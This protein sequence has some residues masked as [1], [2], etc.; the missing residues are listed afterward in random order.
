MAP[1]MKR[2]PTR[3]IIVHGLGRDH[4]G[5]KL[6][7]GIT[8]YAHEFGPWF[9]WISPDRSTFLSALRTWKADGVFYRGTPDDGD[10]RRLRAAR[11]AAIQI[12]WP[13]PGQ[14]LD[15]WIS[16][17]L[18]SAGELAARHLLE[19]G[20][21]R[22]GYY[23]PSSPYCLARG[24]GFA[25]A[26]HEDGFACDRLDFPPARHSSP[27][28]RISRLVTWLRRFRPPV[29]LL[30]AEDNYGQRVSE[31]C[32]RLRL[33]IPEDVAVVGIANDEIQCQMMWPDLTSVDTDY[34]RMGYEAAEMLDA[35]MHRRIVKPPHRLVPPRGIVVRHS[36]NTLA[37][38]DPRIAAAVRFIHEACPRPVPVDELARHAGMSRRSLEQHF[39]LTLRRSPASE[40][41]RLRIAHA[42]RLL[43]ETSMKIATVATEC[44]FPDAKDFW[45]SFRKATG[46]SPRKFRQLHPKEQAYLPH[47]MEP[48]RSPG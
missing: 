17:D 24:D 7:Q 11:L 42:Q 34:D 27:E 1:T 20:F 29:G 43:L 35:L 33:R 23:G 13:V 22:F 21:R 16:A 32:R 39:R 26:L 37:I 4:H 6:L 5:R 46:M 12:A 48:L 40:I 28:K 44:H 31:A 36:T 45:Q 41:R 38:E 14:M 19:L 18:P 10:L 2:R 25:R 9:F 8:R 47:R 3:R 15:H 30:I